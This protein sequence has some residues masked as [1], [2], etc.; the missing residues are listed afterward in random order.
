MGAGAVS[1]NELHTEVRMLWP[2]AVGVVLSVARYPRS[3]GTSASLAIE[4]LPSAGVSRW[5]RRAARK[6]GVR[7]GRDAQTVASGSSLRTRHAMRKRL[8]CLRP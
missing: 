3:R 6:A 7:A 8:A 5:L 2:G 1:T 4:G